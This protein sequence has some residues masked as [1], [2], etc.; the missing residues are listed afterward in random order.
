MNILIIHN[1]YAGYGGENN[2]VKEQYKLLKNMNHNVFMFKRHNDQ[3]KNKNIVYVFKNLFFKKLNQEIKK[4][5]KEFKPDIAHVHNVF[6]L[7]SSQIYNILWQYK[8]PIIQTVHNYRFACPNGIMFKNGKICD[9]CLSSNNF[10]ECVYNK[11]YNNSIFYSIWYAYSIMIGY[12]KHHFEKIDKF[13]VFNDFLKNILIKKGFADKKIHVIPNFISSS[14]YAP[15]YEKENYIVYVG[16]FSE[17]KGIFTLLKS[18]K[19]IKNV[20]LKMLGDGGIK[21]KILE[22]INENNINNV[23]LCGFIDG[24]KKDY[25][26]TKAKALIVPSECYETF[27]LVAIEAFSLGT[28]AIASNIG[29]LKYIIDDG[30]NGLKF[31]LTN[32]NDLTEKIKFIINNENEMLQM[33]KNA[34]KTYIDKYTSCDH[35][36]KLI[37]LYCK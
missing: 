35:Y 12:K 29:G 19:K 6:P 37:E 7:I 15:K 20:N 22:Y 1:F 31:S 5:I 14:E 21:E 2:I 17:E 8:I 36:K 33:S 13:I 10:F 34:Y 16:R 18:I 23:E 11:C 30:Y 32:Y 9:K 24:D 27:G 25:I 26:I 3:I 4:I 28:L